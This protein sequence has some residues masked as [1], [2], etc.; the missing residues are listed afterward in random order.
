MACPRAR[1]GAF[2]VRS[3]RFR[4]PDPN[5]VVIEREMQPTT[6]VIWFREATQFSHAGR[7]RARRFADV[8]GC[9]SSELSSWPL[10]FSADAF[11]PFTWC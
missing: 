6:E 10:Q 4:D 1:L 11:A 5:S 9:A 8:T 7:L 2:C 3:L